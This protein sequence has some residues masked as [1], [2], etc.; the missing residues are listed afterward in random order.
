MSRRSA[1]R[2]PGNEGLERAAIRV[3]ACS[4][5]AFG[6]RRRAPDRLGVPVQKFAIVGGLVGANI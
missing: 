5:L 4:L 3:I 6:M 2:S 1:E